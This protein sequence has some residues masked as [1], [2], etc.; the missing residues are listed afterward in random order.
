MKLLQMQHF[1]GRK[2]G[3]KKESEM[4]KKDRERRMKKKNWN[5]DLKALN[6]H[7]KFIQNFTHETKEHVYIVQTK[8]S[9]QT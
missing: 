9:F 6:C 8:N 7:M 2:K 5:F 3:Y 1:E 4:R